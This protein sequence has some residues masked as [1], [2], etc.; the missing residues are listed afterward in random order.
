M[1]DQDPGFLLRREPEKAF[2]ANAHLLLRELADGDVPRFLAADGW[3][4]YLTILYALLLFR[5]RHELAPLHA[6]LYD[7]VRPTLE[8]ISGHGSY[9]SESFAADMNQLAAW[10][11]VRKDVEASRIRGYKDRSRENFRYTLQRDAVSFLEWLEERLEDR[12]H[13]GIQDGRDLLLDL[14]GRLQEILKLARK[15]PESGLD[16]DSA[17]RMLYLLQ[18]VD[19]G[20]DLITADLTSLRAEM[21][22]FARGLAAKDDLKKVVL[23]LEKYA[24]HYVRRM[25]D[26]GLVAYKSARRLARPSCR[27]TIDQA[28][29]VIEE[30]RIFRHKGLRNPNEIISA[31]LPFLEPQGRLTEACARVE[32]MA[33]EVVRRVH[34]QLKD[35]ERRNFRLEE[36]GAR[37]EQMAAAAEEDRRPSA[38]LNALFAFAHFQNDPFPGADGG[39][40]RPPAPR[41]SSGWTSRGQPA[42][43]RKKRLRVAAVF[44]AEEERLRALREYVR[45]TLLSGRSRGMLS[46]ATLK[47]GDDPLGWLAVAKARYLAGGRRLRRAGIEADARPGELTLSSEGKHV[48]TQEHELKIEN[49][50]A[51]A[52]IND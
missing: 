16:P 15:S 41:K 7:F 27:K 38:F 1:S 30:E 18:S 12:L 9:P 48:W 10:G 19:E 23:G 24:S 11:C 35:L 6:D 4:E 34:R 39:K 49:V 29:S 26:L 31:A 37:L 42:P 21:H 3:R 13:G 50:P 20:I 5:R 51:L 2:R 47:P 43:L 25:R 14:A 52:R 32:Q 45:M 44:E 46:E 22:T 36:L 28:Q 17:R 40:A 33:S 8:T